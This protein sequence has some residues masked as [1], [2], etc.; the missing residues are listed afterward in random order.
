MAF[1]DSMVWVSREFMRGLP[2]YDWIEAADSL[3]VKPKYG[4]EGKPEL[5]PVKRQWLVEESGG[6]AAEGKLYLHTAAGDPSP[7]ETM[8]VRIV[9][10]VDP[11]ERR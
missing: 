6:P 1:V 3:T 8:L 7:V 11:G 4:D 9:R 2:E 5:M 10:E